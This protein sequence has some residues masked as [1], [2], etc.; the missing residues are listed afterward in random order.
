M[1]IP[2][3]KDELNKEVNDLQLELI[4]QLKKLLK[5][6]EEINRNHLTMLRHASYVLDSSLVATNN[7]E[8]I[9]LFKEYKEALTQYLKD[10]VTA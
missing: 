2:K 3:N 7:E 4:S 9:K 6:Q 8:A 5:Q 1:S 10:Q